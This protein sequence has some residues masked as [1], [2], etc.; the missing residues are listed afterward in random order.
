[1]EFYIVLFKENMIFLG[2][3]GGFKYIIQFK[4]NHKTYIKIIV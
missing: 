3:N 4:F 1:M 2:S